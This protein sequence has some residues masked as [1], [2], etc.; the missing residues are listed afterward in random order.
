LRQLRGLVPHRRRDRSVAWFW[1]R[2][3]SARPSGI[4]PDG[5]LSDVRLM[6]EQC[7]MSCSNASREKLSCSHGA[8]SPGR[9]LCGPAGM[10]PRLDRARRQCEF[11]DVSRV[12][13]NRT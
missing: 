12:I 6:T 5:P 11:S 4:L 7:H 1:E 3:R 13:I 8:A 2:G 10:W 9:V